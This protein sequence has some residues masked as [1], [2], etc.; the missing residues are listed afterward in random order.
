VKGETSHM[1]N[2]RDGTHA[3]GFQN[4]FI[5]KPL[6]RGELRPGTLGVDGAPLRGGNHPVSK[7]GTFRN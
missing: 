3:I 7:E 4:G 1:K 5:H 6:I 2:E